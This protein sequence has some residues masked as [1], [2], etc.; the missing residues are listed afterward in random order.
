MLHLAILNITLIL[1]AGCSYLYASRALTVAEFGMLGV[2][3]AFSR[4]SAVL[5][6]GGL[7]VTIIKNSRSLTATERRAVTT[8]SLAFS[9]IVAGILFALCTGYVHFFN[10]SL[11]DVLFIAAYCTP[12]LILFPLT[13]LPTADLEREFKYRRV[14]I[15]EGASGALEF[16][17]P[18]VLFHFTSLRLYS[19]AIGVLIGRGVRFALVLKFSP[20]RFTFPGGRKQVLSG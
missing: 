3:L 19:F 17:L 5:V 1:A 11:Q 18:I 15:A 9:S 20:H 16:L 2:A 6:D 7:K 10:G 13:I 12:I 4:F 14:C 8:L